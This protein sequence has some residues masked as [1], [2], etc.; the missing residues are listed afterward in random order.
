MGEERCGKGKV[1]WGCKK[2]ILIRSMMGDFDI[3]NMV[4]IVDETGSSSVFDIVLDMFVL[5]SYR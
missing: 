4:D 2:S 5:I 3:V 1:R